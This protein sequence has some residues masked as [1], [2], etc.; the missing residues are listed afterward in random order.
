M[1]VV[2]FSYLKKK[3]N[4][5]NKVRFFC[6]SNVFK[7]GMIIMSMLLFFMIFS[8]INTTFTLNIKSCIQNFIS[9]ITMFF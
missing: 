6:I 8:L 5:K 9:S 1:K 3:S 7:N 2:G 4:K